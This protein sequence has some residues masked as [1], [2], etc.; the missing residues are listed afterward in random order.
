M[1]AREPGLSLERAGRTQADYAAERAAILAVTEDDLKACA[2]ELERMVEDAA[3][4][5]PDD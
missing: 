5:A 3:V 1:G 2:D 4:F